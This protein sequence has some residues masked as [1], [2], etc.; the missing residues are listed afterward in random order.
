MEITVDTLADLNMHVLGEPCLV[1]FYSD[2]CAPCVSLRPKI[3]ELVEEKFPRIE[4][5]MVNA[6]EKPG[7]SAGFQVFTFPV[8]ILFFEGKR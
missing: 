1:Y 6:V 8:L 2:L 5:L 7:L 4:L 3:R